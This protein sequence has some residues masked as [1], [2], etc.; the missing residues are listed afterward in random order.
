MSRLGTG[1]SIGTYRIEGL[2][3]EGSMGTVYSAL[4]AG[5]DRRVALKVLTPELARDE[6]F[7]ARF[8]R[9]SRLA[10]SLEHPHIVPIHGAGE[11]DG[12][13]YLAMRY[14][15]G[16]DLAGLLRSLGRLDPERAIAILGQVA[17]ALDVAHARGLV[18]RDV[19]PANVLLTR[20]GEQDDYAYLCDFGLAKHASTVSSL[21]GS[22]AIV[23]TVDYLAPEQI[24]GRPVDGRAD[25]YALGCVLYECLAGAPP[26][27]RGNEL[28]ALLAHVNDTPPPL[29]E[30]RAEIPAALDAV[31]ATALS[32]DREQ[33]HGSCGE[34]LAAARA[35]LHGDAVRAPGRE[36]PATEAVRTFLFADVRGYTSYTRE[37]G[38][39][40]GARLAR[41]FAALV[42]DLAPRHAGMLQELRG[43]EALVVFDAPR[44]ALRFALDLQ[45]HVGDEQ[46]E[47]PVGIGIDAGEAVPIEGGFR[48]GALNR[49]ARL[50]ARAG[51]GAVLATDAVRELAGA[52]SGVAYGFR[53]VERL[54]GFAKPVGIVEVHSAEHAPR[55]ELR[56]EAARALAGQRPR[57]RLAVLALVAAAGVAAI[58]VGA[59][60]GGHPRPAFTA[61]TIGLLDAKTLRPAGS[62]GGGVLGGPLVADPSGAIWAADTYTGG[63][64]RMDPRT[65]QVTTRVPIGISVNGLAFGDG[66][67]WVADGNA[68][69]VNRYD[70]QY[71]TLLGRIDLPSRNLQF[72]QLTTG[73]AFGA[74]S[75][76]VGY[77]KYP[78]RLARVDPATN[79]VIRTFD[80]PN[81]DGGPLVAYGAGSVWL[82]TQDH[83]RVYRIDP[84]TD[85][86]VMRTKLHNGPVTDLA[87]VGGNAWMP[88]QG[89]GA[90]WEVDGSGDVLRSIPTGNVPVALG[91]SGSEL[92]VANEE[93]HSLSRIDTTTGSV[94]TVGVGHDAESAAVAGGR[95]WVALTPTVAD[96]TAGLPARS[97]A[98]VQTIDDPY[99]NLDP[100]FYSTGNLQIQEAV[101]ARLLR[102]PDRAQPGGVTL[103][104]EIAGLPAISNRG[105]TYT[106]TI[107]PGYRFSPPSGAPVTAAVM[108]YS[109][110]RALS[111][112]ITSDPQA[113]GPV[114]TT[115]L[116]GLSAFEAG[117]TAHV[118]G[119]RV[120]GDR[121][122]FDLTAP[123]A[124]FPLRIS[125][126]MFSAVPLGTPIQTHGLGTA[127]PS[128][129]PYYV[130]PGNT[131]VLKRNPYYRGPRPHH[132]AAIVI[133]RLGG[134]GAIQQVA[135]N[136]SDYVWGDT[137]PPA[138]FL[139]GG[140]LDRRFGAG[141]AAARA[142]HRR[143]F[144][145]PASGIRAVAFDATQGIFR[146]ARV[147][148]AASLA[149]DRPALAA[150]TNDVPWGDVLAPG[151]PGVRAARPVYPLTGPDLARAK[152]L[153]HGVRGQA[154][155][156]TQNAQSCGY[157][158]A[159]AAEIKADLAPLGIDVRPRYLP[160]QYGAA[161]QPGARWDLLANTWFADFPDPADFVNALVD[162]K[163]GGVLWTSPWV[164]YGDQRFL[165]A[166]RRA[167][168][169]SGPARAAVYGSLDRAILRTSPPTAVFAAAHGEPQL[170]SARVG[171]QVFR[172]Q[173]QGLVD[174]A[175]LCIRGNG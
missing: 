40:A 26:F 98:H 82:V 29:S 123:D 50:C 64:V 3:G 66:S 135:A 166:M 10:A 146:D 54:K 105:R 79:R 37:H 127:I 32:K 134:H 63:L 144:A 91:A 111:P 133:E 92:Y 95:V 43:D 18:H 160:D 72:A 22:R 71:G 171:C 159:T 173:D 89:D 129:G 38:D 138:D 117:R 2:I 120:A 13:L 9:E 31:I 115:D 147:R 12:L 56:R 55:R 128:A 163:E 15:E 74:G 101:G 110:E 165:R 35:A 84:R 164:R 174:L 75:L 148:R 143:Y 36:A 142:G 121:L 14:V 11:A 99:F 102:Y 141:S 7:R 81:S 168:S 175:A 172:P 73:V 140:A 80:F 70:A 145:P 27:R 83:G 157:C 97:V 59:T 152:A 100:A 126:I 1:T 85:Q 39:E 16:R 41:D 125:Q 23:G 20:H 162:G 153:D 103:L 122:S 112:K 17:A 58:V 6:R 104:P 24:E 48:G 156:L 106:F 124:D 93:G 57:L 28:A 108:R 139:P 33:R 118:A 5:L 114:W 132:L 51:P 149:L 60:G 161:Q 30:A 34:L 4:D 94:T 65:R 96:L 136:R 78:F 76:W 67:V 88:V 77:G 61:N 46:L 8:L 109:I 69:A 155:L 45:A 21:T 130:V 25:V 119:I 44:Q 53:R 87:I 151:I 107:R 90:V 62:V 154:I 68:A 52:T 137:P 169:V 86:V 116:A 170:F 150:I 19:K 113:Y 49:A 131:L 167:Q 47:R 158:Q 42:Q